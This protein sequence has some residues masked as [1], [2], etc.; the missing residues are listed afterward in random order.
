MS[1]V[2]QEAPEM[3]VEPVADSGLIRCIC[4]FT[5][6][7]GLT[8]F[9]DMC[10]YWQHISCV[11]AEPQPQSTPSSPQNT[12][13]HMETDTSPSDAAGPSSPSHSPSDHLRRSQSPS[14]SRHSLAP[15]ST[16]RFL[17]TK[18]KSK[19]PTSRHKPPHSK[20][21]SK[22]I[23]PETLP[24][25]W[26]CERCIPRPVDAAGA[27]ERQIARMV[28]DRGASVSGA[29]VSAGAV[30]DEAEMD[31]VIDADESFGAGPSTPL[32]PLANGKRKMG[33]GGSEKRRKSNAADIG[34]VPAPSTWG[35]PPPPRRASTKATASITASSS[36]PPIGGR[37][38]GK[39]GATAVAPTPSPAPSGLSKRDEETLFEPWAN[40][41]THIAA[42][43]IPDRR[44]RQQIGR[45]A[46]HL[47]D[48][49]EDWCH[50]TPLLS[51]GGKIP[52]NIS[53]LTNCIPV[54][55]FSAVFTSSVPGVSTSP[56]T[57]SLS[58][59]SSSS[60]GLNA[61]KVK[62]QV[63]AIPQ[64]DCTPLPSPNVCP[65]SPLVT[66]TSSYPFPSS[67]LNSP[68][69][70][71]PSFDSSVHTP[72]GAKYAGSSSMSGVSMTG[73]TKP[74]SYGLYTNCPTAHSQQQ[75]IASS[76]S[77]NTSS[78]SNP[79]GSSSS[80][81]GL[82]YFTSTIP[83]G[84]LLAPFPSCVSSLESYVTAPSSQYALLQTAKPFVHLVGRLP[85][86]SLDED[87]GDDPRPLALALDTREMGGEA[88]WARSGCFPNAVIRP[89]LAFS[90]P[91][92]SISSAAPPD[93]PTEPS[94]INAFASGSGA[95]AV[96]G[97]AGK[98]GSGRSKSKK[99][100]QAELTLSWALFSTRPIN[101][102][103]EEIVVGWEWDRSSAVHR[104][105]KIVRD[106]CADAVEEYV[107]SISS[108]ALII[109]QSFSEAAD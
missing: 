100:G 91:A 55:P 87:D 92:A 86:S 71:P 8:I 78:S 105:K 52:N 83:A 57:S 27:R 48:V 108:C 34:N 80:G 104:L 15:I 101:P 13:V 33:G 18:S 70:G 26:F 82:P 66:P 43:V 21:P 12:S 29:S 6:D 107:Y 22:P 42:D 88:R 47:L 64:A 39:R 54:H 96:I 53:P 46:Q 109:P 74:P 41:Y 11:L 4:G 90:T 31:D 93:S 23:I 32:P 17:S 79:S 19:S 69:V 35:A 50:T 106:G 44:V 28:A 9:C 2:K 61:K 40:E 20:A 95:S 14:S 5:D 51:S 63:R 58:S 30:T 85:S 1:P 89:V 16:S 49:E 36:M 102:R 75:F 94:S 25:Q 76:S 45:W 59:S 7:D 62:V 60:Y 24:E 72:T 68:L 37:G 3:P 56:S 97:P 67:S 99:G 10:G 65:A 38:S 77:S 84:T 81:T 73:Y 98:K 103:G